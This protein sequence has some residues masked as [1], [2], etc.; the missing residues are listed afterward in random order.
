MCS[1]K[2]TSVREKGNTFAP[3]DNIEVIE[4]ELMNLRGKV[5]SVDGDEVVILPDHEDLKV[6]N[7]VLHL[8]NYCLLY[9]GV[10]LICT[11]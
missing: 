10:T 2:S 11:F 8:A 7:F 4:G 9:L 3:G 1:V 6:E 5:M